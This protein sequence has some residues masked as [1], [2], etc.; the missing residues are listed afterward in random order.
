MLGVLR[1]SITRTSNG[2]SLIPRRA[3]HTTKMIQQQFFTEIQSVKEQQPIIKC[4][5]RELLSGATL[6]GMPEALSTDMHKNFKAIAINNSS[7]P[8]TEIGKKLRPIIEDYISQ[9]HAAILI[10]NLPIK[11]A[12]DFDALVEGFG[13]EPMNYEFGSG[14]RDK[15]SGEVY[16]SSDE[17]K[18]FIIPPHNELTYA[19]IFPKRVSSYN[20]QNFRR[21]NC[22]FF[23]FYM[24]CI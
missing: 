7:S 15:V 21:G 6:P 1:F 18:E 11:E 24:V 17:P 9:D 5:N 20:R 23:E 16:T 2:I 3:L 22:S 19:S 14:Y 4:R 12:K 8:L 10:K 13:Y